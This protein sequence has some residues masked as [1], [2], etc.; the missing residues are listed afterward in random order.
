MKL[1]EQYR[2]SYQLLRLESVYSNI[3][4]DYPPK[5]WNKVTL[6]ID[7]EG[8]Q[9]RLNYRAVGAAYQSWLASYVSCLAK[10]GKYL[11][12]YSRKQR[13]RKERQQLARLKARKLVDANEYEQFIT[14]KESL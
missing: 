12:M 13:E 8:E 2:Y 4:S 1:R 7:I 11:E 6:G 14:W 3:N 10:P 5:F 9:L